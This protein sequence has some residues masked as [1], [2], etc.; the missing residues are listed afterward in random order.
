M[1]EARF[2]LSNSQALTATAV[3]TDV[4]DFGGDFDEGPGEA[5]GVLIIVNTA[6]DFSSANET[7]QFS[8]ITDDNGAMSSATTLVS[9]QQF[10]SGLTAGTR[11]WLPLGLANEQFLAVNYTLGG[12]T[13]SI[14]C[15]AYYCLQKDAVQGGTIY[16]DNITF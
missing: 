8:L 7:Y 1:F 16:A 2:R 14:T 12:T 4:I 13:P 6:A 9:S 10:T 11:I 15:T 3:S 5:S